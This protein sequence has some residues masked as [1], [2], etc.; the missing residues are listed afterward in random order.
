MFEV[1]WDAL[2]DALIDGAKLLPFL[3]LT[4]F[5]MEWLEHRA[6]HKVNAWVRKSG[7]LGPLGGGTLGA[8]P[9]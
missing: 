1:I 7:K 6:G 4:Y 9:Q 2:L 5:A 3:F 8:V